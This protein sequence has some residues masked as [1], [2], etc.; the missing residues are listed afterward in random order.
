ML[1]NK[2]ESIFFFVIKTTFFLIL[3][4][5]IN[6]CFQE[7][8]I[9]D[10]DKSGTSLDQT[11][12]SEFV[13]SKNCISC[14][15]DEYLAWDESPHQQAMKIAD[16]S[17]V[18]GDFNN[19]SFH[20]KGITTTFFK[21]GINFW[22]NTQGPDG[23]NHDYKIAYTFGVF[24]LQQYLI[25]FPNGAY[26]CLL[27][28]WDAE[29]KKWYD[30]QPKLKISHDEWLHWSGGS[31]TWNNMCADCHSTNLKKSYNNK[32]S[33]YKTT[34][35][36][37]NV[38]CEACHGPSS[39]HVNHYQ[40]QLKNAVA[41]QLRMNKNLP[42]KELVDQCARCH[43]RRSSLTKYFDYKG[44]FM[45]HYT[46]SLLTSPNYELDGQ[47]KDEDY[48]YA[49]FVQSKMYHNG[50]SCKDCHNS[51]TLK[52]KKTGNDLC[53]SC[54]DRKYNQKTHHFHQQNTEGALCINC[55]MTGKTY[56]GNDYRRDHSF[57]IPRPDQSVKYGTPNACI[58]CHKEKSNEWASDLIIE[59]YGKIRKDHFS[60][61]LL[62][63]AKGDKHALNHLILNKKYPAIARATALNYY[64][65]SELSE[66]DILQI[67]S[68]LNDSSALIRNEAV[69]ALRPFANTS[70]VSEYLKPLKLDPIRMIRISVAKALNDQ[71][72][73]YLDELDMN[74]DFA[75]GQYYIG[76]NHEINGRNNLA[77]NAYEKSLTID[78]YFNNS[79]MNLALLV[80]KK[81][82]IA[83]AEKLYLKVIEQEPNYGESYYMLGLLNNEKGNKKDALK[84][85][86][87]ACDKEVNSYKP[88][89]NYALLLHAEG[90]LNEAKRIIDK[91]LITF[92]NNEELLYIKLTTALNRKAY[93]EA[94]TTIN[95]LLNIAP[96]NRSYQKIAQQLHSQR[97]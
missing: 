9:K 97:N 11:K 13:G 82:D 8:K 78:N 53:I 79:R 15:E 89:Y 86:K 80:Y 41:P 59:N 50:V 27:T 35:S 28:A 68:F 42:S 48:V 16:S 43:A 71:S 31:M 38:S 75:A 34:F 84:Y 54:H 77:K 24:P 6:A 30:L 20:S 39:L 67:T 5:L 76:I 46:P 56:M 92:T 12:K 33:T 49:S 57:R 45:D 88:F 47:I 14:H 22:V 96:E 29:E 60:D 17:S 58:N 23:I 32:T 64:A 62:P 52:L 26:Q 70:Y 93:S 21:K 61:Y 73:E 81:G 95:L 3:T 91:A 18:L 83:E 7:V 66:A 19:I 25:A 1:I 94:A 36:E 63:G 37:I 74:S 55:H 72:I 10:I 65:Y 44:H 40:N 4:L 90:E 69:N 87:L 51:H 85:M 2:K